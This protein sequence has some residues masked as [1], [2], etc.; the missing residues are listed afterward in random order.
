MLWDGYENRSGASVKPRQRSVVK[1]QN[2]ESIWLVL[3]QQPVA[4]YALL[5]VELAQFIELLSMKFYAKFNRVVSGMVTAKIGDGALQSHSRTEFL[6]CDWIILGSCRTIR[7]ASCSGSSLIADTFKL[8]VRLRNGRQA[9]CWIRKQVVANGNWFPC[10]LPCHIWWSDLDIPSS[11]HAPVWSHSPE[12]RSAP[13]A[14]IDHLWSGDKVETHSVI[15]VFMHD[16]HGY[17]HGQVPRNKCNSRDRKQ[18][19]FRHPPKRILA[20]AYRVQVWSIEMS[21]YLHLFWSLFIHYKYIF[22]V[23]R[24]LELVST[25]AF[26]CALHS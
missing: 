2:G 14:P 22:M 6:H 20:C 8:T 13:N 3:M 4:S 25:Y 11:T 18:S 7:S 19:T 23:V 9:S 5:Y 24:P 26:V 12:C 10:I 16:S 1:L 21:Q 15:Q 17:V